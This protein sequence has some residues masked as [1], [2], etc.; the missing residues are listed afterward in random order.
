MVDKDIRIINTVCPRN[1]YS[2]CGME[3][4]MK[5][6]E[7]VKVTGSELNDVTRGKICLKGLSYPQLTYS[8]DRLLYP[9]KLVGERGSDEFE[10]INW[11]DV[12]ETIHEKF[13]EVTGA[14][15]PKS[16]LYYPGS[17]NHGS[18]M[19]QYAYGF[20][21]QLEGYSTIRGN[22]CDP[23]G[24]TAI[25]HTYGM[26]KHN[27]IRDIENSKLIILWGKNPTFTNVHSMYH[28][29]RALKNGSKLIAVDPRLN[30]SSQR[31]DLHLMP[32]CGTDGLLAIGVAKYMM[33]EEIIDKAFIEAHV[34]GYEEYK[35]YVES[36]SFEEILRLTEVDET[37][38]KAMFEMVKET[39]RFSLVLG[40]GYQRYTNGGQTTKAIANT[41][42]IDRCC[43]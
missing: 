40:K 1:C 10:R 24:V 3:V 14:Y 19:Q 12:V 21:D 42:G 16:I 41:D 33:E 9:M 17:G 32:R 18:V 35:K 43:R 4:H 6:N 39:P 11:E 37:D 2:G 15:G 7:I 38:F 30:E 29:L 25:K 27:A 5:G 26:V 22:L 34:K 20:W 13:Q 28:I 31:A 23:A 36:W 8:K